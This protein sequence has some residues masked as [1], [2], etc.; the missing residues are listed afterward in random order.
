MLATI[1]G[2]S[3]RQP[4][5][6]GIRGQCSSA[7]RLLMANR[8]LRKSPDGMDPALTF[9]KRPL[10]GPGWL[11]TITTKSEGGS[12]MKVRTLGI[13][14]A[15]NIFSIHGVDDRGKTAVHRE[16]RRRQLLP[17]MRQ[18]QPCACEKFKA[19]SREGPCP[20]ILD[21][22]PP[23]SAQCAGSPAAWKGVPPH[24][25]RRNRHRRARGTVVRLPI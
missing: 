8:P 13:D 20:K 4:T 21:G 25:G 16:L 23:A 10:N 24:R 12:E 15:K 14:L 19:P 6:K 3:R 9:S 11:G 22:S 5:L 1:A 18:L 2:H 17:F 7:R